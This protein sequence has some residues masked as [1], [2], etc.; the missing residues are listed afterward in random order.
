VC[1]II[2]RVLY[3]R[4]KQTDAVSGRGV[5]DVEHVKTNSRPLRSYKNHGT[6]LSKAGCEV[7]YAGIL[8]RHGL[9]PHTFNAPP[10]DGIQA[11]QTTDRNGYSALLILVPSQ[12][13]SAPGW[14]CSVSGT[15]LRLTARLGTPFV[16]SVSLERCRTYRGQPGY[17][18]NTSLGCANT[19]C[20]T[21]RTR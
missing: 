21:G 19:H 7:R 1:V 6:R 5:G 20:E 12:R 11:G 15:P 17:R 13:A 14:T 16:E 4:L 9:L 8:Q 10:D 2:G 18:R 3:V